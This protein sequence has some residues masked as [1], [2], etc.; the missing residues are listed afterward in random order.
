MHGAHLLTSTRCWPGLGQVRRLLRSRWAMTREETGA[1]ETRTD[2]A[3][4]HGE[5]AREL[6]AEL[7]RSGQA[8]TTPPNANP[9]RTN[10]V[11]N[12]CI[13]DSTPP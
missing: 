13:E 11:F 12:L 4:V 6:I 7:V 2:T 1:E 3:M 8:V 5:E 10:W 9:C